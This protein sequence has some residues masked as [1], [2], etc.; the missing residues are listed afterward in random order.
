MP[1]DALFRAQP[2]STVGL[3]VLDRLAG[4]RARPFRLLAGVSA[5]CGLFAMAFDAYLPSVQASGQ[6]FSKAI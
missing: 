5:A 2:A 6:R 1:K 3:M 4:P